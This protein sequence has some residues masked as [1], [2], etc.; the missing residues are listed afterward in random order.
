M[1]PSVWWS[2]DVVAGVGLSLGVLPFVLSGVGGEALVGQAERLR[3]F[4]EGGAGGVDLGGVG[5]ALVS[6]RALLSHRAVVVG[7]GRE[8]LLEALGAFERGV[9]DERVVS[10]VVGGGGVAFLFSGQGSQWA[11]MGRGLY[12]AFP[13][14]AGELDVLVW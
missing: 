12:D 9:V 11:G 5:G 2:E 8:D 1:G 14:F 13:V 10:G 6:R 3:L 7:G 4:V